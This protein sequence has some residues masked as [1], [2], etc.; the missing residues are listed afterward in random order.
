MALVNI[1][2][3]KELTR[4]PD[5]IPQFNQWM[6]P[7]NSP[8][9][10]SKTYLNFKYLVSSVPRKYWNSQ[11][12]YHNYYDMAYAQQIYPRYFEENECRK[13]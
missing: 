6:I 3:Y 8:E 5:N 2:N 9:F 7:A 4:I 12:T 10:N 13:T 11:S 1:N